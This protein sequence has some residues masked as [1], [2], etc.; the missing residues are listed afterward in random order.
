MIY[1]YRKKERKKESKKLS[2][3]SPGF[4]GMIFTAAN[5]WRMKPE[6]APFFPGGEE[7]E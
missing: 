3:V 6:I 4:S 7:S 5:S 2:A 1:N